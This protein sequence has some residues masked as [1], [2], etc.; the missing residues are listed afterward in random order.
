MLF[1]CGARCWATMNAALGLAGSDLKNNVKASRP[2]ADAPTPI[3]QKSVFFM[4]TILNYLS[5]NSH[6]RRNS[7]V[8]LAL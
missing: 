3:I 1:A 4:N 2:P 7:K 6:R 5:L 8:S